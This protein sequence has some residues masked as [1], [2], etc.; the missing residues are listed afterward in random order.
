MTETTA[1]KRLLETK[2]IGQYLKLDSQLIHKL[3]KLQ[4]SQASRG[5]RKLFG[6]IL[7]EK[8]VVTRKKLTT[9]IDQ[10]KLD[11]IGICSVFHG[12][13]KN[14]LKYIN[15]LTRN[16]VIDKGQEFITQDTVGESFYIVINGCVQVFRQIGYGEEI[17][18]E[19]IEP[20]ECIGEM[21]YFSSGRRSASARAMVNSLLLE[22]DYK[23]LD[24]A[25][26]KVPLLAINFLQIITQRLRQSNFKFQETV[27]KTRL[28]EE[29][30]HNL[31]K[32]LDLSEVISLNRGI[33]D[34]I[35]R[36]VLMASKAMNAERATLFLVDHVE[37][38][39][40]SKVAEGESSRE[41]RT[42]MNR[43][44]AGWVATNEQILNI[45]DVYIDPR[46]NAEVDRQTGY[47]TKSILCGP[48]ISLQGELIGVVEVINK[49]DGVFTDQDEALFKAFAYQSAISLE[50]FFLS[51]KLLRNYEKMTSLLD[52][53]NAVSQ[54]LDLEALIIRIVDKISH[55][56]NAERTS[57]F[58]W[59]RQT[60]ELWSKAAQGPEITEIRFPRS[61]GLA[62]CVVSTGETINIRDAYKDIRFNQSID[63][64]TGF[65]TRSVLCTPVINRQGEI[66]GVTEV[67]NKNKGVFDADDEDLLQALSSQISISLENAQLFEKIVN[68]KTYLESIHA[69]MSNCII[70]LDNNYKIVTANRSA[71]TL[72]NIDEKS[73]TGQD[74]RDIVG[75]RNKQIIKDIESVYTSKS[76]LADDDIDLLVH[77]GKRYSVNLNVVPL[78][79]YR[80]KG[81][82]LIV[83]LDDITEEKRLKGTLGRYMSKDI[84]ERVLNDPDKQLLGGKRS[85]ATILFSDIR[86]FTGIAESLSAE[87]T[88]NLLNECF[89]ALTDIIFQ[90]KGILDKYIG[91][92]FMAVFGVPYPR[93]DDALRAVRS[94]LKM[95]VA[96]HKLNEQRQL[97]GLTNI[98][99]GVG[100]ATGEVIAGNIGSKQRMDFTVIGDDVNVS[101]RLEKLNKL[102]GT[103]I[104]ISEATYKEIEGT[105]RIRLIDRVL[106]KGRKRP[107]EI[108]EV[109]GEH[110]YKL[111]QAQM[112]FPEALALYRE[113][114][115]EQAGRLFAKGTG[116]DPV[117]QVFLSRC[118]NFSNNP[119]PPD[120]EG[121]WVE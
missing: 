113:K 27:K 101:E 2:P 29:S 71:L 114:K 17:I 38:E 85:R 41:I 108:F 61:C 28:V 102:Y 57:L 49:K 77:A 39:L 37:G 20:G 33:E 21:G 98:N 81:E 32:V 42:H 7:I 60:D 51:Q 73:A 99:I 89:T 87:Q 103:E 55:I 31:Q 30:L 67:I 3:L 59:D 44:I 112:K 100:I 9:V 52:V 35:E 22:M 66:I 36:I 90:N 16:R 120:W 94:A 56:L 24:V 62:G 88:V 23:A 107:V 14:E 4:K 115:F 13:G 10:Q 118:Q 8:N 79:G 110:D 105:F 83:V 53:N 12:I 34:L 70:S 117:S 72:L 46:F 68:M 5:V 54:T 78:P 48:V 69:S 109:L 18:L 92:S 40:W 6:E 65:R 26:N 91:D 75:R 43:G 93:K 1:Q 104:L 47:R 76:A 96:M 97:S 45:P 95:Q 82:G 19:I 80:G 25:F 74:V 84:V 111:S 106:V 86:G 116:T 119:P 15:S 11:R 64:Q 58:L 121:L 63:E 50:N